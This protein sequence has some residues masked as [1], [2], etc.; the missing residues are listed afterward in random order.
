MALTASSAPRSVAPLAVALA[1]TPRGIGAGD[2]PA[3]ATPPQGSPQN[4]EPLS[5]PAPTPQPPSEGMLAITLE[6]A[7]PRITKLVTLTSA[8]GFGL[9]LAG[10]TFST[11]GFVVS[12]IGCIAGTALSAAG[13]NALNQWWERH[14]DGLMQRTASRPLPT[15]RTTAT[16]A[17]WIGAGLAIAG[18]LILAL[19]CG[20]AAAAVSAATVL[21][22]VLVYTP[23]KPISPWATLVGAVP[24]ALPPLIGWCAARHISAEASTL[25]VWGGL[26]EAGG[27]T[28]FALMM[29]WQIPHFLAIA[30][31]YKDDYARGGHAVLPVFDPTGIKTAWTVVLGAAALVPAT[32]AP[33]FYMPDRLGLP[34]AVVAVLTGL[35]FLALCC[36]LLRRR[37]REQA[38][39]VFIASV[40]HLPVLLLM[41]VAEVSVR[42]AL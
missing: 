30:W 1:P 36:T 10:A 4:G 31:L 38:R 16:E 6:L 40:I 22:Y 29:V 11:L 26:L 41:M 28:L 33:A 20:L 37:T 18:L 32:L 34:Y 27:W 12:A 39:S 25:G 17:F 7:K 35:G 8:V 2:G 15:R 19:A 3:Q 9:G 13:A 24:G 42:A 5:R 14:R 23:M 21:I